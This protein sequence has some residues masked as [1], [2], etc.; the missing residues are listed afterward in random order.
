MEP[1]PAG[2]GAKKS[3]EAI[4]PST[5]CTLPVPPCLPIIC[6]VLIDCP[7]LYLAGDSK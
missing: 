4:V 5:L 6:P 1:L 2:A 7:A 3:M